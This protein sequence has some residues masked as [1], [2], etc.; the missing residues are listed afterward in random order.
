MRK[1]EAKWCEYSTW[2]FDPDE[3]KRLSLKAVSIDD[4]HFLFVEML[5]KKIQEEE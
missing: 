2:T 1:T 3:L 4:K 5:E